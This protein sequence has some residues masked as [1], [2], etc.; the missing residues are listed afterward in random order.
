[1]GVNNSTLTAEKQRA[2]DTHFFAGRHLEA[3]E[4]FEQGLNL[5]M[6]FNYVSYTRAEMAYKQ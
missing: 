2:F 5:G 1:M 6:D 4:A 3:I